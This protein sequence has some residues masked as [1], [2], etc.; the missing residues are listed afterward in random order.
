MTNTNRVFSQKC[1]TI[2][3]FN[4]YR[5]ELVVKAHFIAFRVIVNVTGEK[6]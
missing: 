1:L 6:K 4:M 5:V 3:D 2:G